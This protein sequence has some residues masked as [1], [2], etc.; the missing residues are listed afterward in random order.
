LFFNN[1]APSDGHIHIHHMDWTIWNLGI[2]HSLFLCWFHSF[3][4]KHILHIIVLR[5]IYDLMSS[6]TTNMKRIPH[7][8]LYFNLLSSNLKDFR[9][10]VFL[11]FDF[12]SFNIMICLVTICTI[13]S[14]F[15]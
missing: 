9:N 15:L 6:D 3:I 7:K 8:P 5:T 4:L 13:H 1:L 10:M 12:I 11:S 14:C 2:Y